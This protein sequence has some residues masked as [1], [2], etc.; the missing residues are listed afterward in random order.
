MNENTTERGIEKRLVRG[1]KALGGKAYKFVSPGNAG[2]PDRL[3]ILPGGIILFAELKTTFGRLS[4][5]QVMQIKTLE[6]LGAEAYEVKGEDGVDSFLKL[7]QTRM[8]RR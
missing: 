6:N 2:V 8:E 7:C 3:V 1:V 4:P 5:A